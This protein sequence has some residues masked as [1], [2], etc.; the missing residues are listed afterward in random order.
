MNFISK[1]TSLNLSFFPNFHFPSISLIYNHGHLG[2]P[3]LG[4]SFD[5][6]SILLHPPTLLVSKR[7]H[8]ATRT[9]PPF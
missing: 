8:L 6:V 1:I 2:N 7:K 4:D 3:F 5:Y 9:H